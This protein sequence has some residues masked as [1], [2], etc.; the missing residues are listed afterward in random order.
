MMHPRPRTSARVVSV[1]TALLLLVASFAEAQT[2]PAP[3]PRSG[4]DFPIERFDPIAQTAAYL[5]VYDQVAWITSDSL[6]AL[7]QRDTTLRQSLGA[8]WFAFEQDSVWHAVYGRYDGAADRYIQ[9]A[10]FT[11]RVGET[12]RRQAKPVDSLIARRY[13]RAISVTGARLPDTLAATGARFNTYVRPAAN[14][15]LDIWYLPAWQTNG[16]I[17]HGMEFYYRV[18]STGRSILDST[19]LITRLRGSRPDSSLVLDIE[20][21][22]RELPTVGQAFF[23]FYYGRYFKHVFIRNRDF[24]STVSRQ[25]GEP[26]WFHMLPEGRDSARPAPPPRSSP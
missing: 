18:D 11:A 10:H 22:E 5:A 17:I 8:E 15:G 26:T 12:F 7:V 23:A 2:V 20:N 13:G 9:A 24:V 16:W 4:R 19:S 3:R 14:G 6:V 21:G 25:D 1:A